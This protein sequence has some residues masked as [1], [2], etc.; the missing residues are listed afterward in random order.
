[1]TYTDIL[2]THGPPYC[3]GDNVSLH[4][5][6]TSGDNLEYTG[7]RMLMDRVA[8]LD[9][10]Q[11]HVFGH[12]HAG[13]GCSRQKGVAAKFVNA[14]TLEEVFKPNHK[15]IM[16]FIESKLREILFFIEI[17][18]AQTRLDMTQTRRTSSNYVYKK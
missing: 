15:H 11:F 1:M 14:A 7:D 3:H 10:L 8:E 5:C 12:V 18:G 4:R 17:S 6:T 2:L 16:F 13:M 9:A